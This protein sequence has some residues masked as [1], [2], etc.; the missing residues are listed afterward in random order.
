MLLAISRPGC[1][2]AAGGGDARSRSRRSAGRPAD[3]R[4]GRIEPGG[5][6]PLGDLGI[7]KAEPAMSVLVAQEFERVRR[8]I[9][10]HQDPAA[11][12]APAPPRRS[13]RPAGRH[14]A[15][16][17]GSRPRQRRR[18][19]A[20]AGTCRRAGPGRLSSPARS[21][22]TRATDS[23]S[24]D[25]S[26][27]SAC[28]TRGA[29]ISSIRPVPVPISSRSRGSA[30]GDD[31]D[32]RRLDLAL[33]DIKRADAVPLRGILAE[34]G[35]GELGALPLDRAPGAGDRARSSDRARRR[36][37]RDGRASALAGLDWL[38]R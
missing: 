31:L 24:R 5:A 9:D 13:P 7:G 28:S 37:R 11:A 26:M 10:E 6:A 1:R 32:Q 35:A 29:R 22:L 8:K 27:P 12:A 25:W 19:A 36:R 23:I 34:I 17:D 38:N 3:A 15:A 16:P 20:P 4:R 2:C 14:N 18:R 21:R 30:G 33:V